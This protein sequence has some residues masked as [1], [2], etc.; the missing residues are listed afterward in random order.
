MKDH[1]IIAVGRQFASGGRPIGHMLADKLGVDPN[2]I[3]LKKL[4]I[5][6]KKYPVEKAK[7]TSKKYTEL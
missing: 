3:V 7:G 5:T 1:Y 2:E 6:K 4:E